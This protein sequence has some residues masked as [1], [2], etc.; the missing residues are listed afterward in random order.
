MWEV[1]LGR[2]IWGDVCGEVCLGY[3]E[4]GM[5]VE[6]WVWVGALSVISQMHSHRAS[7]RVCNLPCMMKID[8]SE[9]F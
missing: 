1:S 5:G 9:Y 2:W 7:V 8:F 6:R 4:V 3:G